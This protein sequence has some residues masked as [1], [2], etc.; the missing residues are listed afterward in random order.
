MI[1]LLGF[2][3]GAVVGIAAL[4]FWAVCATASAEEEWE[5]KVREAGENF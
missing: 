4:G 1:F 2:L 5:R 3:I